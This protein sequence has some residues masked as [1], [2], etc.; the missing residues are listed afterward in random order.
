MPLQN[1]T[2]A[3]SF[4]EQMTALELG[5]LREQAKLDIPAF[6]TWKVAAYLERRDNQ[7][8]EGWS[9]VLGIWCRTYADLLTANMRLICLAAP[10]TLDRRI[11]ETQSGNPDGL[12]P[13]K[14]RDHCHMALLN[15]KAVA[16]MV[17]AA[18]DNDKQEMLRIVRT[19]KP[20]ARERGLYS[21]LGE[22]KNGY[23]LY[24]AP[25]TGK[26][27]HLEWQY[28]SNTRWLSGMSIHVPSAQKDSFTPKYA[29]LTCEVARD[30]FQ[31]TIG[32]HMLDSVTGTLSDRS[33]EIAPRRERGDN[34]LDVS[35]IALS[36]ADGLADQTTMVAISMEERGRNP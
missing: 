21:H 1:E 5:L 32:L 9:E 28:K 12:L 27:E 13:L 22:L 19:L 10:K 14:T 29:V 25:G 26:S 6:A 35:A 8:Q 23:V 3:D 36:D 7:S 20:V 31:N 34:F 4:I 15:L 18:W 24:V 2:D 17:R 33:A 16:S 11:S 30:A